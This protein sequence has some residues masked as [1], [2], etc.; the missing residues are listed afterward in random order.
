MSTKAPGSTFIPPDEPVKQ[1]SPLMESCYEML[2]RAVYR[3][4]TVPDVVD[5]IIGLRKQL[6]MLYYAMRDHLENDD[7]LA[8]EVVEALPVPDITDLLKLLYSWEEDPALGEREYQRRNF[9]R[10]ADP[11]YQDPADRFLNGVDCWRQYR[12]WMYE[13]CRILTIAGRRI[14]ADAP[15]RALRRYPW[16]TQD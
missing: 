12:F 4:L 13:S 5:T 8:L 16:M 7:G 9:S 3:G 15:Q 11:I 6:L 10:T 14:S 2:H 1:Y